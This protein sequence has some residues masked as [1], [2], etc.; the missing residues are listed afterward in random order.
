MRKHMIM[1]DGRHRDSVLYSVID[2]EWPEVKKRL[3]ARLAAAEPDLR[4][5]F[6][7]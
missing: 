6:L 1:R 5:G 2:T 7:V 4:E 3:G